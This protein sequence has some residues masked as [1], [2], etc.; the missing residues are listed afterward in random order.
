MINPTVL[1]VDDDADI[2]AAVGE[3][4]RDEGMTVGIAGDGREALQRAA[5]Q[6][7]SLVVLDLTLPIVDG[8]QV[9]DQ[10]RQ[11]YGMVPILAITADGRAAAKARR[12]GAFAYLRKPFELDA[13]VELVRRGLSETG[14]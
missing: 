8:F 4:L 3:C 13:L 9:A 2:R 6:K 11:Q 5:E 7:P 1:I 12:V 14:S 10:I